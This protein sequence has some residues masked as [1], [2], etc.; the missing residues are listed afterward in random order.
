MTTTRRIDNYAL[1][2]HQIFSLSIIN[3]G[4]G[5]LFFATGVFGKPRAAKTLCGIAFIIQL[6]F[7]SGRI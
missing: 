1:D 7:G 3:F 6:A 2:G 4:S 5:F